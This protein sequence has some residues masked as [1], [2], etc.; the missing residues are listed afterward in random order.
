MDRVRYGATC[1]AWANFLWVCKAR[2]RLG[3][4]AMTTQAGK[5][6]FVTGA[7]GFIGSHLALRLHQDGYQV[8]CLARNKEGIPPE[9]SEGL[10]WVQGD[11]NDKESLASGVR[12]ASRVFHCAA[13]ATDWATVREL[14]ASN[15]QG[16]ENLLEA[17]AKADVARFIYISTT[18]VYRHRGDRNVAENAPIDRP[19]SNWYSETKAAAE[20]CVRACSKQSGMETVIVRPGTVFGPKSVHVIG[21]IAKALRSRSMLLIGRGRTIAG[22]C[23]VENLIDL[24]MLAGFHQDSGG[25]IFNAC[26]GSDVTWKTFLDDLSA[27]TDLP[28]A[29]LSFP[30]GVAFGLG[31]VMET[32]YRLLRRMTGLRL[33]ALLSRQAVGVMGKNQDFSLHKARTVLGFEPQVPYET[34]ISKTADWLKKTILK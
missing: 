9:L 7:G 27:A 30:Y 20:S 32:S 23:Y 21:E 34:A 25:N 31:F 10:E 4:A 18:D 11:L 19:F 2:V 22:L 16:T 3:A 26:D 5:I 29:W 13:M 17:A 8:R 6:V 33:P 28:K 24:M 15:V 12:D 1:Y 14:T